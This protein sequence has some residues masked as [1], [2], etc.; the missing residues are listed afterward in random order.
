ME[1]TLNKYCQKIV[2]DTLDSV[3]HR[4]YEPNKWKQFNWKEEQEESKKKIEMIKKKPCLYGR[5]FDKEDCISFENYMPNATTSEGLEG[6]QFENLIKNKVMESCSMIQPKLVKQHQNYICGYYALYSIYTLLEYHD[7]IEKKPKETRMELSSPSL[8]WH[9]K[10]RCMATLLSKGSS[11]NYD[12]PFTKESIES[13]IVERI[14]MHFLVNSCPLFARMRSSI[15]IL[16]DLTFEA[17]A[18]CILSS[19]LIMELQHIFSR[20]KTRKNYVHAFIC[21]TLAHWYAVVIDKTEGSYEAY[22]LDSKCIPILNIST[23]SLSKAVKENAARS[24]RSDSHYNEESPAMYSKSVLSSKFTFF[25]LVDC[26][27]GARSFVK[28]CCSAPVFSLLESHREASSLSSFLIDQ[29]PPPT[30]DR[31]CLDLLRSLNGFSLLSN[32]LLRD[33]FIFAETVQLELSS[34]TPKGLSLPP[35]QYNRML[36]ICVFILS[37][38]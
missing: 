25:F 18:S 32:D 16:P 9:F 4:A 14:H 24:C 11:V 31:C 10:E 8:F 34:S 35:H 28:S 13:G 20:F 1:Q 15:S 5:S 33:F 2:E 23:T 3:L 22:F 21:G 26:A 29:H 19:S 7:N 30:I 12:Y 17:L 27:L 38:K 37:F 6:S 36:S